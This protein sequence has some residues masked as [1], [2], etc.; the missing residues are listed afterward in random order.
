M[1][2]GFFQ[3]GAK[4]ERSQ[5]RMETKNSTPIPMPHSSIYM[6]IGY[7]INFKSYPLCIIHATIYEPFIPVIVYLP[8]NEFHILLSKN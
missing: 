2:I 5:D 8:I 4:R 6:D 7:G 3:N 1:D